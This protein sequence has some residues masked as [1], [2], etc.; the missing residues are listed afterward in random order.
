MVEY[1]WEVV[2]VACQSLSFLINTRLH[3]PHTQSHTHQ[4]EVKV[5]TQDQ[6]N[7]TEVSDC[8]CANVDS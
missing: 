6:P 8:V 2:Y 1:L 4:E 3:P 7:A 5:D